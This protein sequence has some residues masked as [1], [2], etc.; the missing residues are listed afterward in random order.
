MTIARGV[1]LGLAIVIGGLFFVSQCAA[2][3]SRSDCLIENVER[4]QEGL[5]ARDCG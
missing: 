1:A 5:P 3:Q 2:D 4:A